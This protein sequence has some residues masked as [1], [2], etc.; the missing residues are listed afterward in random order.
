MK[1]GGLMAKKQLKIKVDTINGLNKP[2]G[3][4]KQLDSVFFNV[5]ITEAGEKKNLTSQQV[6]LFA[7]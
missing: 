1:R 3:T 5:E 6:K 4:I 7:R 2:E